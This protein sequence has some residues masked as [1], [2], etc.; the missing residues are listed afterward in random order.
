MRKFKVTGPNGMRYIM[1]ADSDEALHHA[2]Q[3]MHGGGQDEP[4]T[5]DV[6]SLAAKP[7]DNSIGVNMKIDVAVG[8]VPDILDVL[9]R[10][11]NRPEPKM[12]EPPEPPE[13]IDFAPVIEAIKGLERDEPKPPPDHSAVLTSIE[14]HMSALILA[15]DE[16]RRE[17]DSLR[18]DLLAALERVCSAVSAP[19]ELVRDGKT[20]RS[21]VVAD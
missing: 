16:Q 8:Q 12:P 18:K 14:D 2:I 6:G 5:I 1:A 19:R 21:E 4:Q 9:E 3:Q 20:M 15:M 10:I 11:A 17:T 13:K 7:K